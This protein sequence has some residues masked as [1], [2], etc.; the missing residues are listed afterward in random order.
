MVDLVFTD[1]ALPSSIYTCWG[2]VQSSQVAIVLLCCGCSDDRNYIYIYLQS[3]IDATQ[4]L[5]QIGYLIIGK[6]IQ[7]S[8]AD[9]DCL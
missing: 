7:A 1:S 6:Y 4:A 3:M 8:A 5:V 2:N 9:P